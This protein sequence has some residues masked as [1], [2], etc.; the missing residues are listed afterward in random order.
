MTT[1]NNQAPGKL[2]L[3]KNVLVKSRPIAYLQN[4]V[5]Y[6]KTEPNMN[7]K[8]SLYKEID[9]LIETIENYKS[10]PIFSVKKN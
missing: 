7:Q 10:E 1:N 9:L 2:L 4:V 5:R 8:D 6:T 3:R